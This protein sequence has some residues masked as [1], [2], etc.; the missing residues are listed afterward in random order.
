MNAKEIAAM[1][2][3]VIAGDV[4][5]E[6]DEIT[7]QIHEDGS[8]LEV[9]MWKGECGP[10]CS[11]GERW[12]GDRLVTCGECHG[13]GWKFLGGARIFVDVIGTVNELPKRHYV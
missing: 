3:R 1:A 8:F 4:N 11:M 9:L 2:R 5:F 10:G 12:G 7:Y 13:Y 6:D